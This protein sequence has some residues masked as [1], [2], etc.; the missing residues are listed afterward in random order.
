M[1][2]TDGVVKIVLVSSYSMSLPGLPV[3]AMLKKAVLSETR[4]AC[5]MLWVTITTVYSFLSSWMSSSIA[6]V[7]IG[8]SAEH[9]SSMSRTSG[10]TAI[11]RAMHR[12]CC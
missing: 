12:R 9:G 1:A 6:N 8:S 10:E 7:E 4:E 5:C 3:P 2:W 11:A